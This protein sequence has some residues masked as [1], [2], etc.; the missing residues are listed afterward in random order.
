MCGHDRF[1][2]DKDTVEMLRADYVGKRIR[3]I[4][5]GEDFEPIPSGSEG[6]VTHVDDLGTIHVK[7]DN[8]RTLGL[9]YDEDKYEL[10]KEPKKCT[11]PLYQNCGYYFHKGCVGCPSFK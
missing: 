4:E 7:W 10:I 6:T 5:M 1:E 8:G 11:N 2:M 3:C 9:V